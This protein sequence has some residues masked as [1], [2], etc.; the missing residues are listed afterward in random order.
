[1][2]KDLIAVAAAAAANSSAA[3]SLFQKQWAIRGQEGTL[4]ASGKH[5]FIARDGEW[6]TEW[7]FS[8]V[9]HVLVQCQG[10]VSLR[11]RLIDKIIH[12]ALSEKWPGGKLQHPIALIPVKVPVFDISDAGP[13]ELEEL[14]SSRAARWWS[15]AHAAQATLQPLKE[16]RKNYLDY[17]QREDAWVYVYEPAVRFLMV[18]GKD[19][20]AAWRRAADREGDSGINAAFFDWCER[21]RATVTAS[22]EKIYA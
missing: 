5:R 13:P 17:L 9:G 3:K 20:D 18:L 2:T 6:Q 1:M 11:H 19:P 15:L 22:A 7:D 21:N 12:T 10:S 8:F 14:V 4:R 16:S